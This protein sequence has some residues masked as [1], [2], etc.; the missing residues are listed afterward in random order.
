[1]LSRNQN[2]QSLVS[3]LFGAEWGEPPPGLS[4]KAMDNFSE[5]GNTAGT[6]IWS[7]SSRGDAGEQKIDAQS[8]FPLQPPRKK[9]DSLR[10][11][12]ERLSSSHARRGCFR[13]ALVLLV[14]AAWSVELAER[15][16]WIAEQQTRVDDVASDLRTIRRRRRR[17]YLAAMGSLLGNVSTP[18]PQVFRNYVGQLRGIS[19]LSGVIGLGWIERFDPQHLPDLRERLA[20]AIRQSGDRSRTCWPPGGRCAGQVGPSISSVCWRMSP[21]AADGST[22]AR[23]RRSGSLGCGDGSRDEVGTIGTGD[24]TAGAQVG[25]QRDPPTF[26]VLAPA[27]SA[28][29]E[30]EIPRGRF[31]ARPDEGLR[32][33]RDRS[34]HHEEPVRSRSSSA[35]RAGKADL[36]VGDAFRAGWPRHC[37]RTVQVFDQHWTLRY[38]P[39]ARSGLLHP[40]HGHPVRRCGVCSA[41]ARFMSCW[42]SAGPSISTRCWTRSCCRRG[43]NSLCA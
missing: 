30:L 7:V 43:A 8:D 17:A 37:R 9:K 40:E 6:I 34:G 26:V 31:R 4:G 35:L 28:R 22:D 10:P 42:C 12:A 5:I 33:R 25:D 18:S 15:R 23:Q 2:R 24:W 14:L 1:M 11:V 20:V 38:W 27:P 16:I 41:S 19:E 29:G 3:P 36:L 32:C 39:Q 13:A 21:K